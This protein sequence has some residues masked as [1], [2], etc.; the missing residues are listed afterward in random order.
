MSDTNRGH[1]ISSIVGASLALASFFGIQYAMPPEKVKVVS[2]TTQREVRGAWPEMTQTQVDAL[3]AALKKTQTRKVTLVCIREALCGGLLLDFDNAFESAHFDT[4]LDT[5]VF[6]DAR[7]ILVSDPE[8]AI[9][10]HAATGIDVKVDNEKIAE[11]QRMAAL[12]NQPPVPQ[13]RIIIG[14]QEN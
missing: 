2:A 6:G 12:M 10:I 4:Q 7:G 8:L 1:I 13:S 9:V 14:R 5:L 11:I 3:T